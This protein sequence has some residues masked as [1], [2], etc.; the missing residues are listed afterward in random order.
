MEET[1]KK[2]PRSKKPFIVLGVVFGTLSLAGLGY[3]YF[4]AREASKIDEPEKDMFPEAN[5]D[6]SSSQIP[7]TTAPKTSTVSSGYPLKK[8][9]KGA[10]VKQLQQILIQKYGA[11]ILPKYGADGDFGSELEAALKSKGYSVVVDLAEFTK[12]VNGAIANPK[13][14]TQTTKPTTST[15]PFNAEEIAT[16]LWANATNKQID[17]AISNLR[18]IKNVSEYSLVSEKLKNLRINGTR[19]NLLNA[20]LNVFTGTVDKVR[21]ELE[22]KRMGLKQNTSTKVWSLSGI[23]QRQN[24]MT[25]SSCF[26]RNSKGIRIEVPAFAFLGEEVSS[27][28][29]QTSFR[30]IDNEILYVQSK[31]VSYV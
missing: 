14:A 15:V 5:A 26:I 29:G 13:P 25:N 3:W 27:S 22:F 24:L 9:S 20:M 23:A 12:I 18:R 30:T 4:F 7:R 2:K 6:P 19:Y 10:L 17:L 11:S 31:N 8:G 21:I 28:G 1:S 16:A